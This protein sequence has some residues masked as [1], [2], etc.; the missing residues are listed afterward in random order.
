MFEQFSGFW[1]GETGQDGK[2][3]VERLY[4]LQLES[5]MDSAATFKILTFSSATND[6]KNENVSILQEGACSEWDELKKPFAGN[7]LRLT[8]RVTETLSILQLNTNKT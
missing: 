8:L 3:Q 7:E 6:R 2:V 1:R 5:Q 4:D